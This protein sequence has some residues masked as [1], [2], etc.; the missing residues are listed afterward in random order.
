MVLGLA[1]YGV[2]IAL[3]VRSRLGLDPW[4][5]F[6]QGLAERTNISI[7]MCVIVVGAVVMLLWIPLHQ[8]PGVGTICNVVLIGASLNVALAHLEAPT[9]LIVRSSY[10]LIGIILCGIATGAYIGA[11]LGPGPRDGIMLGLARR[12]HSIRLA[13]TVIEL[14]VLSAGYFLGGRV[15]VGTVLFAASIGPIAHITI[16]FF[17]RTARTST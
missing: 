10:L 4:D 17:S 12:G 2:A 1:L 5:V 16:P 11:G 8:R 9:S 3:E 13:R 6:H 14:S 7:G 15:G